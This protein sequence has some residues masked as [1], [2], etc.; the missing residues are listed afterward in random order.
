MYKSILIT[1]TDEEQFAESVNQVLRN[2]KK[3]MLVDV[4]YQHFITDN[5]EEY[6]D[7]FSALIIFE[8]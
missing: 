3:E 7:Y 2:I 4:K 8:I 5:D 6:N 1:N